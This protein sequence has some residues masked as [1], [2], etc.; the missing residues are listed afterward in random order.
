MRLRSTESQQS[1]LGQD[2]MSHQMV[3]Q[4]GL[5]QLKEEIIKCGKHHEHQAS[6]SLTPYYLV[7]IFKPMLRGFSYQTS[8]NN[9]NNTEEDCYNY[10]RRGPNIWSP[11]HRCL[12]PIN[13]IKY[14]FRAQ[15]ALVQRILVPIHYPYMYQ[16]PVSITCKTK[17]RT[18]CCVLYM[19]LFIYPFILFQNTVP[20]F[21]S[22]CSGSI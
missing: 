22:F 17:T 3:L 15:I 19:C 14:P 2:I 18:S 16:K 8:Q 1:K 11:R 5:Q 20:Y 6:S 10:M 9:N 21:V 7:G 13:F 4:N 12:L